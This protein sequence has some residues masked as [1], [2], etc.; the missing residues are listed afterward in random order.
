MPDPRVRLSLAA[1]G[2]LAAAAVAIAQPPPGSRVSIIPPSGLSAE[3][4]KQLFNEGVPADLPPDMLRQ[5]REKLGEMHK[6]KSPE[7]VDAISRKLL[8]NKSLMDQLRKHAQG[9]ADAQARGQA[10]RPTLPPDF[11]KLLKQPPPPV[12]PPGAPDGAFNPTPQP[13]QPADE[14]GRPA[15]RVKPPISDIPDAGGPP[16]DVPAPPDGPGLPPDVPRGQPAPGGGGFNP[17]PPD[18]PP[19]GGADPFNQPPADGPRDKGMQALAGLWERNVGPLDDTP[20]VKRIL[21]DI[22]ESTADLKDGDGK[23]LWDQF[24][25]EGGGDGKGF[26]DLF[27]SD[28]L[29]LA[30]PGGGWEFPKFDVPSVGGPDVPDLPDAPRDNWFSR[31][32]GSGSR[33]ASAGSRG[34]LGV[35]FGVPGMEGS[36]LPVVLLGAVLLGALV[37]WR[38]WYL[39]DDRAAAPVAP[40]GLGPWP[41]D[42]RRLATREDVARAF[43]YLSVL[44]CGPV[45]KTWTHTTIARALLD[46]VETHGEAAVM[47]ARLYELARY[48]PADEPLTT[49]EL[50]EARRLVCRLAGLDAE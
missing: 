15:P 20:A 13:P 50:A 44:V 9:R 8:N 5:I 32:F 41:V 45:A 22:V 43:E 12:P 40:G 37:W 31:N 16:G 47:L 29:D 7:E 3:Q 28:G 6:G 35:D 21:F 39:K 18:R 24:L 30:G 33:T 48:A 1:L 23:S 26:G 25:G 27:N 17:V 49:A 19:G 38:F 14:P 42:P 10:G 46:L 34:G 11:E 36:W 4:I 2:L